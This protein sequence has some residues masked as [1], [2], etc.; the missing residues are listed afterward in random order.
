MDIGQKLKAARL[1]S[2]LTQEAVAE[3]IGV[4]RQSISNWE[5]NKSYPDLIN[6]L[7]LSD[8]YAVSLDDLLRGDA[9]A[10]AYWENCT[11]VVKSKQQLSRLAIIMAYLLIW[12]TA[13]IFFWLGG[14]ADAMGYSLVVFYGVLPITILILAVFVGKDAAWANSRWL[15]LL[16]FG[17]LYMLAPYL[18]FSLAN[19]LS[20][21]KW[22][23]LHITDCLPGIF[24][25]AIGMAIGSAWRRHLQRQR[26]D[27]E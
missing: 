5:T 13:V 27:L 18:T 8:L 25:A 7:A 4:S 19:M 16:F 17:L 11:D 2:H 14:R 6:I 10:L 20:F 12:S 21:Q 1:A 23:G 26:H 15:M 9:Q 3:K 24:C 22:N